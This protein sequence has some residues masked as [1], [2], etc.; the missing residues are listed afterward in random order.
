MECYWLTE[1]YWLLRAVGTHHP[2]MKTKRHTRQCWTGTLTMLN[3]L[4]ATGPSLNPA[5]SPL[6]THDPPAAFLLDCSRVT[7]CRR[8]PGVLQGTEWVVLVEGC[9][10]LLA[11]HHNRRF[12]GPLLTR[13]R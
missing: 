8:N 10:V 11:M 6:E 7:L 12:T 5:S 4:D 2:S 13:I 1:C 9:I 3:K